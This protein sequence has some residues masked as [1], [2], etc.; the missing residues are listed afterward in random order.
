MLRTFTLKLLSQSSTRQALRLPWCTQPAQLK[1]MSTAPML[2][3]NSPTA[4]SLVTSSAEVSTGAC[5]ASDCSASGSMSVAMTFAPSRTNAS[6]ARAPC[7]RP[8]P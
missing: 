4:D 7:P 8:P 6:A 2:W 3:T 5:F 1:R